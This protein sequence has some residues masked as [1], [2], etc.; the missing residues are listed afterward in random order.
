[1]NQN[2]LK[3]FIS[4]TFVSI[5]ANL[6]LVDTYLLLIFLE[7]TFLESNCVVFQFVWYENK[8]QDWLSAELFLC[9]QL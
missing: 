3:T 6:S 1:M 9:Y 7:S 4:K 5:S 8:I 2:T